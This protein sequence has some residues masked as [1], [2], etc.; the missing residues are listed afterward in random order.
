MSRKHT[1]R[2]HYNLVNPITHAMMGAAVTDSANLDRLRLRELSAIESFRTGKAT[3]H[4][5]MAVADL[6]NIME[7]LAH[8]GVG[9]EALPSCML[10][11]EALGAAHERFTAGK[12][13]GVSGPELQAMRDAYEFHDLQRLSI[14]RSRYEQSIKK[15]AD[16]IRSA[17][18]SMKVCIG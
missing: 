1:R 16:R 9:P 4:D 5:W 12:S 3:K 14:S 2:Q 15:T 18:A 7:T 13:L 10:A 11:Q 17:P 8:D 6:L